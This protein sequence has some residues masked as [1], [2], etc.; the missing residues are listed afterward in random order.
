[1]LIGGMLML[2][3]EGFVDR[4]KMS[5]FEA[6]TS[7]RRGKICDVFGMAG[8]ITMGEMSLEVD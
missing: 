6:N 3:L 8:L 2:G 7:L 5:W 1:M 4:R